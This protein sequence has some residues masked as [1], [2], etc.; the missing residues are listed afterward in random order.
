MLGI[1]FPL[2]GPDYHSLWA[3]QQGA[4]HFADY[5]IALVDEIETPRHSRQRFT[6]GY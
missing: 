2:R 6:V 5:A 4:D 3:T 1:H